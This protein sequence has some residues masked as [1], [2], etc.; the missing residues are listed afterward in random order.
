[1]TTTPGE[2]MIMRISPSGTIAG[3]ESNPPLAGGTATP[4]DGSN[5][6]GR[7]WRYCGTGSNAYVPTAGGA[8]SGLDDLVVDLRAGYSYDIEVDVDAFGTYGTTATKYT[9]GV[10]GSEDNGGTYAVTDIVKQDQLT[11]AENF[12]GRA[13][14]LVTPL[15]GTQGPIN[16]VRV[17][18]KRSAGTD[19]GDMEYA[20]PN[21]VLR[22]S[23]YK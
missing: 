5:Q 16:A 22:I 4:P 21:T 15:T 2:P 23:E 8:A 6:S 7:V 10:D 18:L 14:A 17:T 1:M 11:S 9:I 20:P 13:H 3:D 19:G 12:R